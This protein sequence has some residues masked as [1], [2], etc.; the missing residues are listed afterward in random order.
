MCL[1]S[2]EIPDVPED[3]LRVV[4]AVVPKGN[5]S[6]HLRDTLGA[7]SQDD[8]FGDLFPDRGHPA[9]APWR[10]AL[11]TVFQCLENL[12]DRPAA[13]AVRS[14][15]DGNDALRLAWTDPGF[16]HMGLRECRT[17]LVALTAEERL[18]EAVRDLCKARGWLK[19]RG[20]QRT[21]STHVLANVRAMKRTEWVVDTLRH[22]LTLLAV[23]APEWVRSQVQPVWET[24]SGARA[25][26]CRFPSGAQKRQPVEHQGGQDGWGLLTAITADPQHHW[27]LSL[28]AVETLERLWKQDD[29]PLEEGGAWSADEDRLE[30]ANR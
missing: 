11:V 7:I 25:S 5:R 30:A 8:L 18:G 20:H 6:I 27:M 10:L 15:L 21:D 9:Y 19:V 3:M 29:V 14:R 13:D 4:R 24:R 23:V 12:P 1:T 26:E 16:T 2:Q 17:R 22:A 28:P